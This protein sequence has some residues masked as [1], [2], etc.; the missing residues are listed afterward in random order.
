METI[1]WNNLTEVQKN[2]LIEQKIFDSVP[3]SHW[4]HWH[5]GNDEMMNDLSC[6]HKQCYPE[7][8]PTD[9]VNYIAAAFRIIEFFNKKGY[10]WNLNFATNEKWRIHLSIL[11]TKHWIEVFHKNLSEAI[12]I[13]GLKAKGFEVIL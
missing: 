3:C 7:N 5:A 6:G 4:Y 9:Y 8:R 13:A 12:C 11:N 1:N 2:H 10:N